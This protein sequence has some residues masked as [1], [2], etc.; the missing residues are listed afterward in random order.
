MDAARL[1]NCE[2]LT[3]SGLA[4]REI[5]SSR[6]RD[7]TRAYSALLPLLALP[8]P[9]MNCSTRFYQQACSSLPANG[10]DE[11]WHCH[12][13]AWSQYKASSVQAVGACS[14]KQPPYTWQSAVVAFLPAAVRARTKATACHSAGLGHLLAEAK[15]GEHPLGCEPMRSGART[16]RVEY[17]QALHRSAMPLAQSPSHCESHAQ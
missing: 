13:V 6:R 5:M 8:A 1:A 15:T 2:M 16:G 12:G 7:R 10:A 4:I 11:W 3:S 14:D 9:N 17:V